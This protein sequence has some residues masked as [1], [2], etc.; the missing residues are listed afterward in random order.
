MNSKPLKT[1]EEQMK[2]KLEGDGWEV[3][4]KGWPD[5]ACIKSDGEMIFV[6]V[7]AYRGDMLKKEQ[8]F[9]LTSLARL[10]LNCF[11]W[12]P[13]GG[14]EKI[15]PATPYLSPARQNNR[16]PQDRRRLTRDAKLS[17]YTKEEQDDILRREAN[18]ETVYF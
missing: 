10:G 3:I 16:D 14:F 15:T 1:A 6:E 9:I 12:T 11:K 5:F 4:H 7:K 17:R 13:D 2:E 18:G 8:H